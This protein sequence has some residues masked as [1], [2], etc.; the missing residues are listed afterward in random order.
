[1]YIH[2]VDVLLGYRYISL[3]LVFQREAT[4]ETR[5]L[6]SNH[7]KKREAN[8]RRSLPC[9]LWEVRQSLA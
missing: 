2:V 5:F 6:Q 1:M 9:V 8:S 7:C 3:R 4:R